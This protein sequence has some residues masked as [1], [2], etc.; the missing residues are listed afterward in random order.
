MTD[1]LTKYDTSGDLSTHAF[2]RL[3]ITLIPGSFDRS[4]F[5]R[6]SNLCIHTSTVGN[7]KRIRPNSNH[8]LPIHEA[9]STRSC[10]HLPPTQ[11]NL[12]S[13]NLW[14]S[15]VIIIIINHVYL[16]KLHSNITCS[17]HAALFF[18]GLLGSC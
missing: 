8:S 17:P 4:K 7:H 12:F 15:R 10:S 13:N 11:Q 16:C 14:P 5:P 1:K 2:L 18:F 3:T 9:R 6:Q